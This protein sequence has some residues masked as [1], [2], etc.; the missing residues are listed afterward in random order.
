MTGSFPLNLTV[1]LAFGVAAGLVIPLV[2]LGHSFPETHVVCREGQVLGTSAKLAVPLYLGVSPPGGLMNETDVELYNGSRTM[3]G[4]WD[5]PQNG[6]WGA[7]AW[8]TN[9]TL[10]S[11]NPTILAGAGTSETC[12][13]SALLER[14]GVWWAGSFHWPETPAG[15]GHRTQVPPNFTYEGYPLVSLN[16]AYASSPVGTF[17]WKVT[18][19]TAHWSNVSGLSNLSIT[20]RPD[21]ERGHLLGL[22]ILYTY[23]TTYFGVPITFANGSHQT[24]A[25]SYPANYPPGQTDDFNVTYI[26]PT[27]DDQGTWNVYLAGSGTAYPVGGLLF[28]QTA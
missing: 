7:P 8:V 28:E 16:S 10:V 3:W 4:G 26:F 22:G 17:S 25:G 5:T 6:T 20:I 27:A 13:Q 15:V 18:N 11:V 24:V 1:P 23:H 9:W 19:G 2:L 14:D 12:P 21:V